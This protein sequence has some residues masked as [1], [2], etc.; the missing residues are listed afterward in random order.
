M[1][2]TWHCSCRISSRF[3]QFPKCLLTPPP[4]HAALGWRLGQWEVVGRKGSVLSGFCDKPQG[5]RSPML[6]KFTQVKR[7]FQSS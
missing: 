6:Q 4:L 3:H 1:V 7:L 5:G 2:P